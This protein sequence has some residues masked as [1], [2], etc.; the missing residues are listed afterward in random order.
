MHRSL[1]QSPMQGPIIRH[2]VIACLSLM[3]A[4][5]ALGDDATTPEQE[6]SAIKITA[7]Q[8]YSDSDGRAGLCDVFSPAGPP[9]PTGYPAVI[10]VHGGG[11]ISG[12]KWTVAGYSRLLAEQGFVVISINYRLAP[13]FKFPSQVDDVRSAL[14]WTK[15]HAKQWSIDLNRLGAFGYSAGGHL[16]ALV[17]SLADEPIESQVAA[18]DWSMSDPRWTE[19]PK[20]NAICIGGPPCDFRAL[21]MDNQTLSF[22]LGGSRR[23]KPSVYEAASPSAHTSKSDPITQI[24]HGDAD[25]IVPIRGSKEFHAAQIAAGVDSRMEVMPRQGHMMTF[26]N[27]KTSEMVVEFFNDVLMPKSQ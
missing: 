11:W 25:S 8:R 23:E 14:L 13:T 18:S 21:P 3:V 15:S 4:T 27:P 20:I 16:T 26:M 6:N 5:A 19:L 1:K 24:I 12:D 17:A 9:P 7:N 2:G 10:V 22:F